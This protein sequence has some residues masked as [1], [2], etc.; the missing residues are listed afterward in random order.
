MSEGTSKPSGR[1]VNTTHQP[2]KPGPQRQIAHDL[3]ATQKVS[4][5]ATAQPAK[6]NSNNPRN[7]KNGGNKT[8]EPLAKKDGNVNTTKK[9]PSKPKGSCYDFLQTGA[10]VTGTT[11]RRECETILEASST[12]RLRIASSGGHRRQNIRP[13]FQNTGFG[14]VRPFTSI[15]QP[16]QVTYSKRTGNPIG[17]RTPRQPKKKQQAWR[18]LDINAVSKPSTTSFTGTYSQ[19]A[20]SSPP[21]GFASHIVRNPPSPVIP[22]TPWESPSDLAILEYSSSSGR[23]SPSG[24]I[25]PSVEVT[26]LGYESWDNQRLV[27]WMDR[28]LSDE[29]KIK[30]KRDY[31]PYLEQ[32]VLPVALIN[33]NKK[34]TSRLMQ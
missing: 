18:P 25:D 34:S 5:L 14:R 23:T 24:S 16:G 9:I 32:G 26:N 28:N 12:I 1:V 20:K 6:L 2:S 10:C 29:V 22:S 4:T 19:A 33:T 15:K 31:R 13:P 8:S 27:I 21:P 17:I 11:C 3:A 30:L 7:G